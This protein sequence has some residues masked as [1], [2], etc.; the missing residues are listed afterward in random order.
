MTTRDALKAGGF[1]ALWTFLSTF[2]LCLVGWLNDVADWATRG[3][4]EIMFPDPSLLVYGALAA[5]A[6]AGAGFV[7][8]V[9]RLAQ[10]KLGS[11]GP[12]YGT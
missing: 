9:V 7:A 2:G 5:A 11:G 1:T 8:L 12:R 10:A 4:V 6:G 3:N